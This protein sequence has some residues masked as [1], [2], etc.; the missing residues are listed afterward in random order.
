[1]PRMLRIV[2]QHA[3][4]W[5]AAWFGFPAE[6]DVLRTRL[7]DLLA[8]LEKAGRDPATLV[9]TAGITVTFEG[10]A[11][12]ERNGSIHG[13]PDEIAAGL[14]GYAEL[15]IAHLIAHVHPRTPDAVAQLGAAAALARD[16][17]AGGTPA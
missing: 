8:A 10:A 1:M 11:D 15:G 14:A 16:R 9:L 3:A 6:A 2:A 5:N 12:D 17:V 13:T 4:Q 7:A